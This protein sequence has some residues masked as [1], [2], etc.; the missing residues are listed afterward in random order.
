MK[1][2]LT[3]Y[4]IA[5]EYRDMVM[6]LMD[7]DQDPQTIKDT[8]EGESFP[9]EVKAQNV[10]FAVRNL[11]TLAEQIKAAEKQMAARRKS[12]EARAEAVKQYLF[13]CMDLAGITRID[14]PQ[15]A[16]AIKSNPPAVLIEDE[17]QLPDLYWR[18]PDPPPPVPDKVVI[19]SALK[20]GLDV[21]GAKLVQGRRLEIK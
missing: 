8:I 6:R 7:S 16:L 10:A 21:P 12:I 1:T 17:K 3:L 18:L 20:A 15:F 13:E 5:Q 19:G 11:E 14:C 9:L 2:E 4:E